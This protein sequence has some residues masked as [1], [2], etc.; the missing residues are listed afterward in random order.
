MT[1]SEWQPVIESALEIAM[2]YLY[3]FVFFV[4]AKLLSVVLNTYKDIKVA[5]LISENKP[6]EEAKDT[7]IANLVNRL[8]RRFGH[9]DVEDIYSFDHEDIKTYGVEPS[10]VRVKE[11]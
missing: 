7:L 10:K 8:K 11:Q 2:L 4:I 1:A 3:F 5:T 9:K 6:I